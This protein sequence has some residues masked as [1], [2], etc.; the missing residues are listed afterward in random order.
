MNKESTKEYKIKNYPN[1]IR[2]GVLGQPVID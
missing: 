2:V 1:Q